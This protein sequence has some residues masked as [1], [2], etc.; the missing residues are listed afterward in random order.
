MKDCKS[1]H[2]YLPEYILEELDGPMVEDIR[3]HLRVCPA[4]WQKYLDL[5]DLYCFGNEAVGTVKNRIDVPDDI[6]TRLEKSLNNIKPVPRFRRFFGV[7]AIAM[8]L[9]VTFLF[10][11]TYISPTAAYYASKIPVLGE[12]FMVVDQGIL[13]AHEEGFGQRIDKSKTINGFTFTIEEIIIDKTRTV[14]LF[15]ITVPEGYSFQGGMPDDI[16]LKDQFGYSYNRHGAGAQGFPDKNVI[17]GSVEFSELKSWART[18]T[19]RTT[20]L[21]LYGN[22]KE[23]YIFGNWELSFKVDPFLAKKVTREINLSRKLDIPGGE[24]EFSKVL[25]APSQTAIFYNYKTYKTDKDV[26]E[27]SHAG[28]VLRDVKLRD[29]KNREY[30]R[31][32]GTFGT[33]S[34]FGGVNGH[35]QINF[36]PVLFKDPGRVILEGKGVS[37]IKDDL[38]EKI[39]LKINGVYPRTMGFLN[40]HIVVEKVGREHGQVIVQIRTGDENINAVISALI[41]DSKGK[42]YSPINMNYFDKQKAAVGD[43][44]QAFLIQELAFPGIET[45]AGE[46]FSLVIKAASVN[47]EEPW[48]VVIPLK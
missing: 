27:W 38:E 34:T 5:S 14:I 40:G 31:Q 4:C 23:N 1:I 8:I 28:E 22:N 44:K 25:L 12:M 30:V 48:Q 42:L 19:F 29:D 17:S 45:G 20:T 24:V 39:L 9:M 11:S 18:L 13:V 21:N 33:S 10:L 16:Y 43:N 6:I 3:E 41:I 36:E 7:R 46:E 37:V 32:G 15:K 35:G 26:H 2:E 47:L